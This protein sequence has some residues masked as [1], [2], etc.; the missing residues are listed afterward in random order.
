MWMVPFLYEWKYEKKSML[1]YTNKMKRVK[2]THKH[3]ECDMSK[4]HGIDVNRTFN[5]NVMAW[6]WFCNGD[7]VLFYNIKSFIQFPWKCRFLSFFQLKWTHTHKK[8]KTFHIHLNDM[9]RMHDFVSENV[10]LLSGL[11]RREDLFNSH[12]YHCTMS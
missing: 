4:I 8:W 2:N 12:T 1:R 7:I 11:Y 6:K 5:Q 3:T 9:H 10:W